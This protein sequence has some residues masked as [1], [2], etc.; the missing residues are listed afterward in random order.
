MILH[1]PYAFL[2]KNFKLINIIL[3]ILASYLAY[4]TYHIVSFF[5]SYITSN[6]TGNFYPGFSDNYISFLIY[7]LIILIIVG[8]LSIILLFVYKKKPIKAYVSAVVYYIALIIF[9]VVIKNL[10]ITLEEG[11]I[12]AQVARLYRDFSLIS[13]F[14]QVFFIISFLIRGLGFNIKKFNFNEDLKELE[15]TQED[16]EEVEINIKQDNFKLQRN[17]RRFIR[18]FRYYIKENKFIFIVICLVL[19]IAIFFIIK[20]TL[21]EI[22]DRNYNQGQLFTSLNINYRVEDSIITNLDYQG[23]VINKDKY[24]VVIKLYAE[25]NLDQDYKVDFYN[26][27]LEVDNHYVYPIK[28]KGS[29]FIDYAKRSDNNNLLSKT[30]Y[31][32]SLV[33]EIEGTEVK[34]NYRLKINNGVTRVDNEEVGKYNYVTITPIVINNVTLE[35]Q[36]NSNDVINLN[37]SNLG[38]T[39]FMAGNFIIDDKYIYDYEK[40]INRKCNTYKGQVNINYLKNNKTLLIFDYEFKLDESVPYYSY[41]SSINKF[42]ENFVKVRYLVK[43][44][45]LYGTVKNVTPSDLT[46]KLVLEVP[47]ELKDSSSIYLVMIIRN[48]EYRIKVK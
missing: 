45:Y 44:E 21:P 14:P 3:T 2:I 4:R 37:G 16:S 5:N 24:Y 42:V 46:N 22:V 20:S 43:D 26:F 18:E 30:S 12:T 6:Y 47:K 35:N 25:N 41:S 17:L 48:K 34:K 39:T 10:M 23:N 27:R 28:D 33:Y 29:Y 32:Y 38:N 1:K 9:F 11:T 40:C 31:V 19:G 7:F 15:L 8:L 36:Y 13:I